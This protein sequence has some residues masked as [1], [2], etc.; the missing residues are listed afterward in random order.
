[1]SLLAFDAATLTA[2]VNDL[3]ASSHQAKVQAIA[4]VRVGDRVRLT[5]SGVR[6]GL[7]VFGMAVPPIDADLLL[8][9]VWAEGRL[10]LVWE[11]EALRGVPAM[12]AKVVGKPALAKII[13][14]ALG[15]RWGCGQALSATESGDLVVEPGKLQIPGW[16]G[17]VLRSLSLPGP[18][19]Y[20]VSADFAWKPGLA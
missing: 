2:L 12:A 11:V 16:R 6:T 19:A 20:V 15:D 3:L 17:L 5:L 10:T 8:Q 1:M 13:R 4:V 18:D 9:G 7:T 14:E